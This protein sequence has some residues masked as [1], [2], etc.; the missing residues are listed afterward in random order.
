MSDR[1]PGFYFVTRVEDGRDIL[2]IIKINHSG[3]SAQW[4][5]AEVSIPI[6]VAEKHVVKWIRRI[7]I[8]A[9]FG[10]MKNEQ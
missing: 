1:K 4:F 10:V 9:G 6:W 2:D 5:G 8:P 7:S 3:K